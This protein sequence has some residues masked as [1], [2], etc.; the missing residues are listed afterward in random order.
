MITL[1]C[2]PALAGRVFAVDSSG[3]RPG[4]V[5]IAAVGDTAPLTTWPDRPV[6]LMFVVDV[7]GSVLGFDDQTT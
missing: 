3:D 4:L 5:Q 2:A 1:L 7:T 6:E